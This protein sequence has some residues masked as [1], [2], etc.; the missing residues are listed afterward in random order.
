MVLPLRQTGNGDCAH[1]SGSLKKNWKTAAVG[2]IILR[3][4]TILLLQCGVMA[5]Q[6]QADGVGTAVIAQ[7]HIPLT[8]NPFPIVWSGSGHGAG[9]KRVAVQLNV[10]ARQT[11]LRTIHRMREK[12]PRV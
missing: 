1:A 12:A 6:F 8:A 11:S 9:E 3:V 7:H 10:D 2:G 4:E 5:F